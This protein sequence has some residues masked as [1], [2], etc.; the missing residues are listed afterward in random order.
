MSHARGRLSEQLA[1]IRSRARHHLSVMLFFYSRYYAAVFVT[2]VLSL[3]AGVTFAFVSKAGWSAANPYLLNAF[4]VLSTGS[5]YY[6]AWPAVFEQR[7]NIEANRDQYLRYVNL[8]NTVLTEMVFLETADDASVQETIREVDAKMAD[9]NR[10]AIGVDDSRIPDFR[11]V[12]QT[13]HT[14]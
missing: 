1:E 12:G 2:L 6:G 4:I 14:K 7:S 8:E 10:I 9:L 11:T 5:L 13:Q 3:L